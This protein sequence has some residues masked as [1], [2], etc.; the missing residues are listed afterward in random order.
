ME[1]FTLGSFLA[2]FLAS[3]VSENT[4]RAIHSY[5]KDK[6]YLVNH[7]LQK[8][9]KRSFLGGLQN[10][11][12]DCRREL[13]A[14]EKQRKSF[15]K[16][17]TDPSEDVRWLDQKRRQLAKSLE[18]IKKE[19]VSE[20]PLES[21][22]EIESLL[23]PSGDTAN[24]V[25]QAVREKL[26]A[27]A[28]KDE[29]VPACYEKAVRAELFERMCSHFAAE[30]KYAPDVRHIF[31]SQLLVQ[32]NANQ[33]DMQKKIENI[34]ELLRQSV[35]PVSQPVSEIRWTVIIN[36]EIQTVM[37]R[38]PDFNGRI[39]H[40]SGDESLRIVRM[41]GEGR[42]V[43]IF[44]GSRAGF[45]RVLSCHQTQQLADKLGMPVAGVE[46]ET[47]VVESHQQAVALQTLAVRPLEIINRIRE[48]KNRQLQWKL[49]TL[50][51][52]EESLKKQEDLLNRKLEYLQ[53]SYRI[54][55]D[56]AHKFQVGS[57]I[58]GVQKELE[59]V[60]NKLGE[61]YQ[62]MENL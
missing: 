49:K 11:A 62:Q 20:I 22:N 14:E 39:K 55:A 30:I 50:E 32:I 35:F 10:I 13:L 57:E 18:D 5:I 54:K 40:L 25:I 59:A 48:G 17:V 34:E 2:G 45:E 43:L 1:G 58:E 7:D 6:D 37:N 56:D 41:E 19:T 4:N 38:L 9:V 60:E 28:I 61:I 47:A 29:T 16:R 27:E 31:D 36:A 24:E 53:E 21:F 33:T 26:A 52:Q 3:L 8:A 15:F 51:R 46:M 42:M 12:E 23:K 44:E